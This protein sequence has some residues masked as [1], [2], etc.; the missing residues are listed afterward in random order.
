MKIKVNDLGC[1]GLP[2]LLVEKSAFTDNVLTIS[3]IPF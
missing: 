1:E 3:W 2:G